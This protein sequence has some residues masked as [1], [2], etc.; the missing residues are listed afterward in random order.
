MPRHA[1]TSMV[2]M[3]A[4]VKMVTQEALK[5]SK[6]KCLATDVLI[7]MNVPLKT[8]MF[9]VLLKEHGSSDHPYGQRISV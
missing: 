2:V 8:L 4:S 1:R 3:F 7:S 9:A 5:V 6:A